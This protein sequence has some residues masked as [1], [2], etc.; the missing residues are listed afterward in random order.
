MS[1]GPRS[2]HTTLRRSTTVAEVLRYPRRP[3]SLSRR[4]SIEGYLYISPFLIGFVL[5]V[6]GPALASA[7]LSLTAYQILSAPR[8]VLFANYV[9]AFTNDPLMWKAVG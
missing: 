6:L 2:S 7:Y 1:A 8:F 3:G 5:F 4:K 9:K